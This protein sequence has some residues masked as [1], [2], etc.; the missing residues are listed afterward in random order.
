MRLRRDALPA[1][2]PRAVALGEELHIERLRLRAPLAAL[3]VRDLLLAPGE[4]TL[5]CGDSGIGKSSLVDVLAGMTLPA[6]F[7]ARVGEQA[8][9]FDGYRALVRNGAYVSQSVRPWQHTVRDC[10][11]W[12]A[13]GAS[14]DMMREVL[15]DVGLDRW[16]AASREGID[17]AL[18]GASSRLSGGELQ[19]LMLAQVI[20]RQPFLAVLDEATG[21]L[22]A[23]SELAVLTAFKRRLPRSILI[24]VSHRASVATMADQ[25]LVIGRDLLATVTRDGNAGAVAATRRQG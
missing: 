4:L 8:I 13:P 10:L 11:L 23:A 17:A 25:Q 5:V 3:E 12:A 9:D 6:A 15:R 22:D 18:D 20:L 1:V 2:P 14:E 24:V 19:R 21:A 7:A 16:L